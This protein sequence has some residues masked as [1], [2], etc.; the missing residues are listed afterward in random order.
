LEAEKG[1]ESEIVLRP[2]GDSGGSTAI[3][4]E[5]VSPEKDGPDET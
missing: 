3:K 5:E 4:S 2:N 1:P